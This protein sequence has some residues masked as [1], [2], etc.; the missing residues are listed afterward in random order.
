VLYLTGQPGQAAEVT[1]YKSPSCGCCG[2][3]V[4]HMREAGYSVEG[5]QSQDLQPLKRQLGVDPQLQSCHTAVVDGYV[6]EGHVPAED[7]ERLLTERPDIRGLAVP[8]MPMG[9]PG[10]QG[11]RSDHYDV[12]AID[13][14]GR[15]TLFSRH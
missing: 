13:K 5:R 12:Y 8:G 4:E 7:V 14:T 10:M 1:V 3:W 6:I 9:A 15:A 11:P 2:K